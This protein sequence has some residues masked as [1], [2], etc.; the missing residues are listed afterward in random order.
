[1]PA[2]ARLTPRARDELKDATRWIARDNPTA[3][4]ALRKAVDALTELLAEHPLVGTSR[5]ELAPAPYRVAVVRGFPYLIVYNAA[6]SPPSVVRVVH[7]ARD[8]PEVLK[9]L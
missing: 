8:L 1:M 6:A 2:R 3:A 7:G 5:P 9:D 4:R